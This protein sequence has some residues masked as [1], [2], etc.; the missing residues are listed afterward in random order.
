LS[1]GSCNRRVSKLSI[2]AIDATHD[3]ATWFTLNDQLSPRASNLKDRGLVAD[4]SDWTL[5]AT[6]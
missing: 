4:A 5:H 6:F 2:I 3:K 1:L